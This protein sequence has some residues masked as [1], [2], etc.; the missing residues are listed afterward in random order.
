[1]SRICSPRIAAKTAGK[2]QAMD[3]ATSAE[4]V[5]YTTDPAGEVDV[6][7][8]AVYAC[9]PELQANL[10]W[11]RANDPLRWLRPEGYRPF[12][13]VSKHADVLE[14]ARHPEVFLSEPR[15]QLLPIEIEE[16]IRA[17]RNGS[18]TL[19]R[20]MVHM[21]EPDHKPYRAMTQGWFSPGNLRRLVEPQLATLARTYVDR[22]AAK[23]DHCDFADEVAV[24]YPLR[25]IMSILGVPESDEAFMLRLTQ[26]LF[27]SQ[28][29]A[30][31]GAGKGD[32]IAVMQQYFEYFEALVAD[33]RKTPRDDLAT[34][35]AQGQLDGAPIPAFEAMSYFVLIVTAGH[36][37]TSSSIAGGL[38]ALLENP[39]Q[40]ARLRRDRTLLPLAVD[41]MVRWAS[42]TRHFMRTA[43]QDY[44]LRGKTIRAGE[45]L[46]LSFLS[47][48][49]DAEVF[50]D[51]DRF[52]IDRDPNPHLGFGYGLHYCLGALLA[53]LE[54]RYFFA[55][56]LDRLESIELAG[57]P[58]WLASNFV[59]GVKRLPVRY[60]LR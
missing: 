36:D 59:S 27:G 28:D 26:E 57:E 19:V 5:E 11:L 15:N 50:G 54:L 25:V 42:P 33:R 55:E 40:L 60:H 37:T 1:V 22:M 44:V 29:P 23:G 8:D 10:A 53:K 9:Q 58:T 13:F 2:E 38:L 3:S 24:W 46:F 7:R 34:V 21:D 6:A 43:K 56:L 49:R 14:A 12:W 35:I 39:D 4:R 51:P 16:R 32:P 17:I 41:E 30:F 31:Q 45:D 47:A 18:V 20:T 48:N 52:R